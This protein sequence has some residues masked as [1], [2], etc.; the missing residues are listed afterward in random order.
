MENYYSKEDSLHKTQTQLRDPFIPLKY[1]KMDK[2][3]RIREGGRGWYKD[4]G[5]ETMLETQYGHGTKE[6][7]S[8]G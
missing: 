6:G 8:G 1:L 2:A 7:V 3:G 5:C 4:R